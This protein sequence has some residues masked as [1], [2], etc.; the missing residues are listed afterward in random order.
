MF[1]YWV[2]EEDLSS[3]QEGESKHKWG[4]SKKADRAAQEARSALDAHEL[5]SP[6]AGAKGSSSSKHTGDTSKRNAEKDLTANH[7]AKPVAGATAASENLISLPEVTTPKRKTILATAASERPQ[8]R[9]STGASSTPSPAAKKP[10][11][12]KLDKMDKADLALVEN[13]SVSSEPAD[14]ADSG[15]IDAPPGLVP[16]FG[17]AQPSI[18]RASLEIVE[19]SDPSTTAP[20]AAEALDDNA[21]S[22][23]SSVSPGPDQDTISGRRPRRV[24][25]GTAYTSPPGQ[26]VRRR[27]QR[28]ASGEAGDDKMDVDPPEAISKDSPAPITDAVVAAAAPEALPTPDTAIDPSPRPKRGRPKRKR[29]EPETAEAS[30]LETNASSMAD[31]KTSDPGIPPSAPLTNPTASTDV[32]PPKRAKLRESE[33]ASSQPAVVVPKTELQPTPEHFEDD[34]DDG[35]GEDHDDDYDDPDADI[36]SPSRGRGSRGGR[37][38]R[39]APRGRGRG[40]GGRPRGRGGKVGRP[41]RQIVDPSAVASPVVQAD[42]DDDGKLKVDPAS[43]DLKEMDPFTGRTPLQIVNASVDLVR[44][45]VDRS[46]TSKAVAM[47]RLFDPDCTVPNDAAFPS[48]VIQLLRAIPIDILDLSALP[49]LS[50]EMRFH[51]DPDVKSSALKLYLRYKK[52]FDDE[53]A[54]ILA[55]SQN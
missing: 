47:L 7:E 9:T 46:D 14:S 22:D 21:V 42:A 40:R 37:G 55:A 38:A 6:S 25:S 30:E 44:A 10:G 51:A 17:D 50:N 8:R 31:L 54:Q 23:S 1:S 16:P 41:P 20:I 15:D 2:E 49:R 32:L 26:K 18:S 5:T 52:M 3:F 29:E 27:S 19:R 35:D 48:D 43:E 11:G 33:T 12:S 53:L 4:V 24:A 13:K 36:G 45:V 39:G 34:W 28:A